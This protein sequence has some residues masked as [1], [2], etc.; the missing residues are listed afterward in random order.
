VNSIDVER[1]VEW[2]D[3]R[4]F[5]EHGLPGRENLA[6]ARAAREAMRALL[7]A[8]NGEPRNRAAIE[9]LNEIS[10]DAALRVRFD[11]MGGT[12]LEPVGRRPLAALLAAV[13]TA[14]AD[15]TW[16]RLKACRHCRWVFYDDSKNRSA[17]W[18]S[19]RLCGNR[20]KTRAYRERRGGRAAA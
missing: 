15:G 6:T 17:T 2:L 9:T 13:H 5:R 8:N 11:D 3:L 19:M 14:M 16:S 20:A 18:C 10:F 12:C 1:G 4:W 7:R